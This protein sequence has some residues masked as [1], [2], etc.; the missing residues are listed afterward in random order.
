MKQFFSQSMTLLGQIEEIRT[1]K[2]SFSIRLRSNDSVL[3]YA[4]PNTYFT[5]MTN[6]DGVDRDRLPTPK[7]YNDT[8]SDRINKYIHTGNTVF[9]EGIYQEHEGCSRF[10]ARKI[11]CM[12]SKSS[13]FVFEETHW[14]LTQIKYLADEWLQDLFGNQRNYQESDFSAMYRTNLNF[15]GGCTENKIQVM[16]T[17]SRFIYG[18]SSAYLLTGTERYLEAAKAGVHFQR[19]TFRNV[20]H[21]GTHIFWSYGRK[22]LS[23]GSV[24]IVPSQNSDDFG[25][26]ALYEQIYA[27]A[28][29][30]QYFRITGDLEV[31]E[32][33][34]RTIR[35]F[36][37][38]FLD[39]KSV[40]DEFP[41]LG[42]YF[43]HIDPA[44]MRPDTLKDE[45]LNLRKNWNSIGDHIPAYLVNLLLALEPIPHGAGDEIRDLVTRSRALLDRTVNYIVE[46]FPDTESVYV[47]E[48]FRA[49]WTPDHDWKWQ[50]NRGI[51]GHNLK[52][53]WN[54]TRVA[55]YYDSID[56]KNDAKRL[57]ALAEKIASAMKTA[58]L[59]LIRGGCFD[60]V[61]RQ[62]KNG[63]PIQFSWYNTKDFWQQEQAILA[64]LI[65]Y[66]YTGKA[67]YRDLARDCLAFWN[68]F[69]LDK[70]NR[71][72]FFRTT[73][74]GMPVVEGSNG[75]K[76]GYAIAGYHAFE[77]NYLAHVYMRTYSKSS[78]DDGFCFYF[79]PEAHSGLGSLNVL[80]DFTPPNRLV[81]DEV[82]IGGKL[83]KK[84]G[85]SGVQIVVGQ[86][87]RGQEVIV[88][89]R[90]Q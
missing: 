82:T 5:V 72:V 13:G 25:S 52:I 75:Q 34:N 39:E 76:A 44:T 89:F 1:E 57:V 33:I 28:G 48:R 21:N 6:L 27:L 59:D 66:E 62:P 70:D 67:E 23:N 20:S 17:L 24:I 42:G 87:N 64:Y 37:D 58:G 53:A 79:R 32:D 8:L 78:A 9:V 10:E 12:H 29:L 46:K 45:K 54:L 51:V 16:A 61:E 86:E 31:L 14:W 18:L 56:R 88:K 3:I 69:F 15:L 2:H 60:A 63:Q 4:S 55:C 85:D 74:N 65:L 73:E 47:N 50:Q 26:I 38:F 36:D 81:V 41:G 84:A 30:T 83:Q 22:E 80:P 71:G 43:S 11:T 77:L 7:E 90:A 49:D 19:T 35:A 68:Q 40:N